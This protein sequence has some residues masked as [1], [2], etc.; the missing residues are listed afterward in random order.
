VFDLFG[1]LVHF[2]QREY[3]GVLDEMTRVLTAPNHDFKTLWHQIMGQAEAYPLGTV[4]EDVDYALRTLGVFT[5]LDQ[6]LKAIDLFCD[7]ERRALAP[8]SAAIDTLER[9]RANG[10]RIGL[11]TNCPPIVT[12][13]WPD[14][15]LASLIDEAVFSC[16]EGIRKPDV[17]VY[18]LACKRLGVAPGECAYVRDG[19]ASD[20]SGAARAGMRAVLL[21]RDDEHPDDAPA[22]DREPWT[23]ESIAGLAELLDLIQH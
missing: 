2:S 18:H 14:S 11:I 9:I 7:F 10:V 15:P 20:V 5:H 12:R 8:R 19:G 16:E 3:D 17:R 1:T 22:F 6:R 4:E 13:F 21:R 23:G